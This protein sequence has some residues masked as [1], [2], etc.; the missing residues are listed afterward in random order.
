MRELFDNTFVVND[1]IVTPI[2]NRPNWKNSTEFLAWYKECKEYPQQKYS[3]ASMFLYAVVKN[4][5]DYDCDAPKI[6]WLLEDHVSLRE[7]YKQ[8]C[9]YARRGLLFF[10]E[11][12]HHCEQ[13]D[14]C[15]CCLR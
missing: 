3:V 1:N 4:P 6:K 5:E 7:Y 10:L 8:A 13:A 11:H 9:A 2:S 12:N 15:P 14:G